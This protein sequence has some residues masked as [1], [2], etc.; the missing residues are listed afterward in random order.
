MEVVS[1]FQKFHEKNATSDDDPKKA[2]ISKHVIELGRGQIRA[3][4]GLTPSD[5]SEHWARYELASSLDDDLVDLYEAVQ[6]I[7]GEVRA[8]AP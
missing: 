4:T 7:L 8:R 3:V 1:D 2:V 6:C 5:E